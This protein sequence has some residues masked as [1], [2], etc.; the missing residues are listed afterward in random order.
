MSANRYTRILERIFF[1]HF[2][3]GATS[4]PFIREEIESAAADLDTYRIIQ[5]ARG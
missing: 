3:K 5:T 2:K 1:A 4:V